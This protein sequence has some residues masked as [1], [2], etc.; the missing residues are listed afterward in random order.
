M[1][2]RGQWI[3]VPSTRSSPPR[4][5][6]SLITSIILVTRP[7]KLLLPL[8]YSDVCKLTL[9]HVYTCHPRNTWWKIQIMLQKYHPPWLAISG[10]QNII[11]PANLKV[12]RRSFIPEHLINPKR[13]SPSNIQN[14]KERMLGPPNET[15]PTK[16]KANT[17]WQAGGE[18]RTTWKLSPQWGGTAKSMGLIW[19]EIFSW[20]HDLFGLTHWTVCGK[21][22]SSPLK[23]STGYSWI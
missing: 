6:N 19:D 2:Q 16:L 17:K 20:W 11:S 10:G 1:W 14:F 15:L 4:S 22:Q 9:F 13:L 7:L 5:A 18:K 23:L 8:Y 21:F 12:T 3:A